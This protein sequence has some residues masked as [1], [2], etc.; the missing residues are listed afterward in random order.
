MKTKEVGMTSGE[1]TSIDDDPVGS[2][3]EARE[4][5]HPEPVDGGRAPD[6]EVLAAIQRGDRA[7]ALRL[8]AR[9]HAA[10]VG[11]LC[12][13]L[14][15]SQAESDDLTQETLL[16]AHDTL[17][18]YRAEGSVRAWLLGI[19][20]R[21]CAR[22]LER[23]G[24]HNAK[25]HLVPTAEQPL[26]AE[27]LLARQRRAAFART[28]LAEVRPSEREALLLRYLSDLSYREVADACSIEEA[29]A[30]KRVSRA[31]ARLRTVLASKE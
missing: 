30:R 19:A 12:M 24:K 20:R 5:P 1:A 4:Q 13:A 18:R 25:F 9:A 31:I 15:G 29:T 21:K 23:R 2:A 26:D 14:T 28:A 16:A 17:D 6:T 22:H 11:R 27:E 10:T 3:D 8:C 7:E